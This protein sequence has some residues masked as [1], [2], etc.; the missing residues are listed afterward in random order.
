MIHASRIV[1]DQLY[2]E[3]IL[4]HWREPH[5]FGEL[6]DATHYAFLSNPLC[7]DEIGIQLR[8]VNN[9]IE[10][11]RFTGRGCAI[12]M[13]AA[14]MLTD[15]IHGKTLEEA[16]TLTENDIITLLGTTPNPARMKC[17]LLGLETLKKALS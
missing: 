10:D 15:V 6:P 17:A 3:Q 16:R 9:H 1:S 8:V 11:V 13:A 4:E 14:S 12:S 5:H 7:G 2:R